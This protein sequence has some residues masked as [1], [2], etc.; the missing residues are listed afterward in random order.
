MIERIEDLLPA[1]YREAYPRFIAFLEKYYEWLY[2]SSGMSVSE[3]NILRGDT[4]W[5]SNDIDRF[6]STGDIKYVNGDTKSLNDSIAVLNNTVNPG[7]VANA[8]P[9]G[10][11]L[12][13]AMIGGYLNADGVV[14][15]DVND[16]SVELNTI[17]NNILDGWFNSM[18][19]DRI[20]RNSLGAASNVDQVLML[21]MLK[22]MYAIKGTESSMRLFFNVFFGEEVIIVQPKSIIAIID[23]TFTLDTNIVLRDDEL[24]Q[25]YSYVIVVAKELSFYKELFDTIYMTLVHPSGFRVEMINNSEMTN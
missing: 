16:F 8:L 9:G 11:T 15:T 1:H 2:R 19:W 22:H 12:E 6:I 10:Y 23:D 3:I 5:L 4:S 14:S 25:E 21:S 17:E 24:Y 13:S 18:G 7:Q 20:K